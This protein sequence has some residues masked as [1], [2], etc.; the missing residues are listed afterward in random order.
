MKNLKKYT[1]ISC[2]FLLFL[3]KIEAQNI[4]KNDIEIAPYIE[5]S[6]KSIP[7]EAQIVLLNKLG[8]VLTQNGVIKGINSTFILTANTVVITKE[9]TPTSPTMQV[10]NFQTTFY[11]GNGVDGNLF[12]SYSL[13][14]KGIGTNE[15]KAYINAFKNINVKNE[16]IGAFLLNAKSKIIDYYN[17]KCETIL[18][19]VSTLEKTN[20]H[21]EA[22]Y[23]LTSIPEACTSCYAKCN[24]KVEYVYKKAIDL[25]CKTKLNEAQQFWN[26]NPNNNGASGVITILKG[27]NPNSACFNE[28]KSFGSSISKKMN[29]NDAREWKLFYE[30]QVGLEKDKIEAMREIGKAYGQGQPKNITYNTKYWW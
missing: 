9:I 12:S 5:N 28:I 19:Q 4:V 20:R 15:T 27:I 25:E 14:L 24:A 26:A 1:S 10:Y 11:I 21:Q 22:L 8:E 16:E 17:S 3:N 2:F 7:A 29:E 6:V 13:T 23:L 18:L 30:Q